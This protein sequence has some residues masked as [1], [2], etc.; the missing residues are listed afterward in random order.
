MAYIQS[1]RQ[2]P[3]ARRRPGLGIL[4]ITIP[5]GPLPQ[6]SGADWFQSPEAVAMNNSWTGAQFALARRDVPENVNIPTAT[7]AS[8]GIGSLFSGNTLLYLAG[9]LVLI[10]LVMPA[11]TRRG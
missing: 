6:S 3:V 11:L 10:A 7:A 4:D 2:A 8:N 5:T 9:A 1:T